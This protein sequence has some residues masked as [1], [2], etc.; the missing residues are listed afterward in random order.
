M[1]RLACGALLVALAAVVAA[2]CGGGGSKTLSKADYGT[3]LNQICTDYNAKQKEIGTPTSIA[4][5]ATKGPKLLDEFD[6]AIAKADKLKAPDEIKATRDEFFTKSKAQRDLISKLIDA[7]KAN[8]LAKVNELGGQNDT[9]N[10]DVQALAKNL[11]APAC[12]Q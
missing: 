4:E 1:K 3:Q 7:A 10:T 8:D 5:V 12:G 6:K 2:G 11:G 9:L